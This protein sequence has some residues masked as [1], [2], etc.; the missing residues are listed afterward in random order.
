MSNLNHIS[1][2][3]ARLDRSAAVHAEWIVVP[4]A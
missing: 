2:F 1:L 3:G 4:Q